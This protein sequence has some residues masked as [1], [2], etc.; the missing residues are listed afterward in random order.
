MER[1][2]K[3]I[4]E[5]AEE[6]QHPKVEFQI[7]GNKM[8]GSKERISPNQS[9]DQ[10]PDHRSS[11]R[12]VI[13]DKNRPT[14]NS[15]LWWNFK[16]LR[17]KERQV[18]REKKQL[19]SHS[20]MSD[21]LWPRGLQHTRPPCPS[22]TPGVCPSSCPLNQWCHPT[23]SYSITLFYFCLQFFPQQ[24]RTQ[25]IKNNFRLLTCDG[26]SQNTMNLWLW[27]DYFQPTNLHRARDQ[28]TKSW[29]EDILKHAN[30]Q[31][32]YL[33]SLSATNW[34]IHCLKKQD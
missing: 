25:K 20:V 19:F 8:E 24:S 18:S 6:D 7:R 4:R 34:I 30:S 9:R 27:E 5:P 12:P 3:N 32:M 1:R 13:M 29:S 15:T 23:I 2:S 21:S 28:F 17:P 22:L 33:P 14:H 26:G 16:I 11:Q 31:Q 10:L